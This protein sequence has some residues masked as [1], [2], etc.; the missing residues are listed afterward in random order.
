VK[1]IVVQIYAKKLTS[2]ADLLSLPHV[3]LIVANES[4]SLAKHAAQ[5]ECC[6]QKRRTL[7]VY[8]IAA[9]IQ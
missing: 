4:L 8:L 2:V 5:A 6:K 9:F 3:G 7:L 1:L